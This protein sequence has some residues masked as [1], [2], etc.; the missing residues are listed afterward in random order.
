[1]LGQQLADRG[2]DAAA[3]RCHQHHIAGASVRDTHEPESRSPGERD[4]RGTHDEATALVAR[5]KSG[6]TAAA[7]PLTAPFNKFRDH[8]PQDPAFFLEHLSRAVFEAG[9]WQVAQDKWHGIWE[10]FH[11]FD[12]AQVAAMTPAEITATENDARVIRNKAKIRATVQTPG[13]SSPYSAP[14]AASAPTSRRSR[15]RTRPPRTYGGAL[16]SSAIPGGGGS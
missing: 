8:A 4:G 3:G 5:I 1:L 14:T 6:D 2:P 15:T 9:L 7:D 13:K 16:S 12:P 11:G 10:A